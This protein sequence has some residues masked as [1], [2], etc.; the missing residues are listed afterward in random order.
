MTSQPATDLAQVVSDL[1][2]ENRRLLRLVE[3]KDEQIRLLN[4]EPYRVKT[5]QAEWFTF[6][7]VPPGQH[8]I[9]KLEA[10]S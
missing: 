2:T 6:D 9:V 10:R 8:K 3:L 7:Q 1:Q 5:G 4:F